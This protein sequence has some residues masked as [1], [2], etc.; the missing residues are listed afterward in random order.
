M[1]STQIFG[2]AI[3]VLW[4]SLDS[5]AGHE[6]KPPSQ[7]VQDQ[8]IA[9][10]LQMTKAQHEVIVAQ[11]LS[12]Y[13]QEAAKHQVEGIDERLR[14]LREALGVV[15]ADKDITYAAIDKKRAIAVQQLQDWDARMRSKEDQVIAEVQVAV[16]A[17]DDAIAALQTQKI[18]HNEKLKDHQSAWL[19]INGTHRQAQCMKIVELEARCKETKAAETLVDV[20]NGVTES[21]LL[22][23]NDASTQI[24]HLQAMVQALQSQLKAALPAASA[25]A[26]M[27]GT[28]NEIESTNAFTDALEA[29]IVPGM[30]ADEKTART[31]R[32]ATLAEQFP[33]EASVAKGHGKGKA[34]NY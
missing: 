34:A 1:N 25:D 15:P 5:P 2:P 21:H 31:A 30:T 10:E 22:N 20:G 26:E 3:A 19:T 27:A 16:T 24:A 33:E 17:V 14:V 29:P 28:P 13:M 9:Q 32:A 4:K 6:T 18:A 11:T 23:A 7:T 8:I 12:P